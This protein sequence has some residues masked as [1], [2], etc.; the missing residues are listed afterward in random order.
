MCFNFHSI[1]HATYFVG[2]EVT[3]ATVGC[4]C[5]CCFFRISNVANSYLFAHI[6]TNKYQRRWSFS[7]HCYIIN[8]FN[9]LHSYISF[10]L[11][12]FSENDEKKIELV[13]VVLWCYFVPRSN[14]TMRFFLYLFFYLQ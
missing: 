12:S 5:C 2:A 8:L 13:T 1:T 11:P 14:N 7:R 6:R 4:C 3:A 10:S 9:L